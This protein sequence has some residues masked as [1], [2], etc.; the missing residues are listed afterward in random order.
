MNQ[1]MREAWGELAEVFS[2]L[3]QPEYAKQCMDKY[4]ALGG[5]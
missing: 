5:N 4:R 2:K 1:N 3:N